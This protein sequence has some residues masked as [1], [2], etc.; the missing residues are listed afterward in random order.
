MEMT[1]MEKAKALALVIVI[2]LSVIFWPTTVSNDDDTALVNPHF[3]LWKTK[4]QIIFSELT[5]IACQQVWSKAEE[6]GINPTLLLCWIQVESGFDSMAISHKGA[7]GLLQIKP[8][9]A[10]IYDS[11]VTKSDLFMTDVNVDLALQH[12]TYLMSRYQNEALAFTAYNLG[13]SR[14]NKLIEMGTGPKFQ[15][16]RKIKNLY[17]ETEGGNV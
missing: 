13:E 12:F 7:V 3:N 1:S 9:T 10:R 11:S 2:T 17:N 4:A 5:D 15:Y 8:S 6:Y 14:L 16:Y